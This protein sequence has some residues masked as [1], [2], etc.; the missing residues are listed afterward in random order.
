[1]TQLGP[2]ARRKSQKGASGQAMVASGT[3][4]WAAGKEVPSADFQ[5]GPTPAEASRT[6]KK[7]GQGAGDRQSPAPT[8]PDWP[9]NRDPSKRGPGASVDVGNSGD[10]R[11][12]QKLPEPVSG[13]VRKLQKLPEPI[14]TKST[15]GKGTGKQTGLPAKAVGTDAD[16]H[17]QQV[18]A[19]RAL[20]VRATAAAKA[21]KLKAEAA[22]ASNSG[23]SARRGSEVKHSGNPGTSAR[24]GPEV[25]SSSTSGAGVFGA[26]PE[27][28]KY[29]GDEPASGVKQ[30]GPLNKL[31]TGGEYRR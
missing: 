17:E 22:A 14:P 21:E 8:T 23:A 16:G 13:D 25:A 18:D 2:L 27:K 10:V 7:S 9:I 12:L 5:T 30:G 1:M 15:K 19:A 6:G 31:G 3:N 4:R 28:F 11:K 20:L 26:L 29:Q 24:R